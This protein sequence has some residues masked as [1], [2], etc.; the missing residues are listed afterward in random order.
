MNDE[1]IAHL[2]TI[3]RTSVSFKQL[4]KTVDDYMAETPLT[5]EEL[6]EMFDK[7][8]QGGNGSNYTKYGT[9]LANTAIMYFITED[10]KYLEFI[11]ER[12]NYMKDWDPQKFY[13]WTS[14]SAWIA[15]STDS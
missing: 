6:K 13:A 8:E 4:S 2:K 14:S 9:G 10:D 15:I 1:K 3:D 12:L 5:A 11:I 7:G